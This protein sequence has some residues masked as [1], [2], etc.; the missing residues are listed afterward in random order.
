MFI[1]SLLITLLLLLKG[2]VIMDEF[3]LRSGFDEGERE[4]LASVWDNLYSKYIFRNCIIPLIV[5]IVSAISFGFGVKATIGNSNIWEFFMIGLILSVFAFFYFVFAL[6]LGSLFNNYN[7][8]EPRVL[9]A[10]LGGVVASKDNK[11]Y[12]LAFEFPLEY[13]AHFEIVK[14][15]LDERFNKVSNYDRF[16]DRF[17]NLRDV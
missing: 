2:F 10:D 11:L 13:S 3:V 6:W 14:E 12:Q 15:K 8:W 7:V 17:K 4:R 9:I 5:S 16:V 1:V